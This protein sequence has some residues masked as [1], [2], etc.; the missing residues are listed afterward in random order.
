[1]ISLRWRKG[2]TLPRS[3]PTPAKLRRTGL[4]TL[5]G[6]AVFAF[7]VVQI[8]GLF[9]PSYRDYT[10]RVN[11]AEGA[12]GLAV[13]NP[14][15]VAGLQYGRI[16]RVTPI[17]DTI[18]RLHAI[19]VDFVVDQG[20][21]LSPNARITRIAGLGNNSAALSIESLGTPG[22]GFPSEDQRFMRLAT[23]TAETSMSK[24][25]GPDNAATVT[26]IDWYLES[27]EGK[28]SRRS[29][30]LRHGF[31]ELRIAIRE[32][33]LDLEPERLFVQRSIATLGTR[34]RRIED[35]WSVLAP[36]LAAIQT[37]V[38]TQ[39]AMVEDHLDDWIE[40]WGRIRTDV[41]TIEQDVDGLMTEVKKIKPR[42]LDLARSFES[43]IADGR[44]VMTT[45]KIVLPEVNH[46]IQ[47]T[48]A[49]MVLA[50]G[51]LRL[52]LQNLLPIAIEAILTRPDQQSEE[53]R[54]LLEAVGDAV[55]AG[56]NLEDAM[57]RTRMLTQRYGDG[58]ELDL[59]VAEMVEPLEG[60]VE[61]LDRLLGAIYRRLQTEIAEETPRR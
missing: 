45:T 17:A 19:E 20:I 41:L 25:I 52:A 29:V 9:S 51:Q 1:M 54:L 47:R 37:D 36:E 61:E 27:T 18:D 8:P 31:Q 46:A 23:S 39:R 10:L 35:A 58:N 48:L 4:L 14:V 11:L 44:A 21:P 34:L 28:L 38:S 57:R 56:L 43:A 40:R 49:R 16:T 26:A 22:L 3:E 55:L 33:M 13:G 5:V 2:T 7:L 24:V 60:V 32:L 30:E 15:Y 42:M 6:I 59:P 50:G 53:R 12:A